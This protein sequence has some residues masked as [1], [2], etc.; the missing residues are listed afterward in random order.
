MIHV[1]L[2]FRMSVR[3]LVCLII[4]AGE[5]MVNKGQLTQIAQGSDFSLNCSSSSG[6]ARWTGPPLSTPMRVNLG[7]TEY[8][9][10]KDFQQQSE[11]Q[12]VCNTE[13]IQ[14]ELKSASTNDETV[15][16]RA[17][18]GDSLFLFCKGLSSSSLMAT[19]SWRPH[20][21]D[22][23]TH[24]GQNSAPFGNRLSL[25]LSNKDNDFS[26]TISP[27]AWSDSGRYECQLSSSYLPKTRTVF[28]LVVVRGTLTGLLLK[29]KFC[30]SEHL[31]LLNFL[32]VSSTVHTD[33]QQLTEGDNVTLQCEVS[34]ELQSVRLYWI[35]TETQQNFPNPL[36]LRNVMMGQRNWACAAFHSSK[37]KALIPLTL[38]ISQTL[39]ATA[40][41]PTP[42]PQYH[43]SDESTIL[44]QTIKNST[45]TR[46]TT[47][48]TT[49]PPK[50]LTR[51]ILT[52]V[53][54]L[55]FIILLMV[56]GA[57]CW[58]TWTRKNSEQCRACVSDSVSYADISLR[59][60]SERRKEEQ[61]EHLTNVR[62]S[63]TYAE[64]IFRKRSDD[65]SP[66]RESNSN[67]AS[68]ET[69]EVLYSC[70]N[71]SKN[72]N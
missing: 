7:Q 44:L 52:S 57:V 38:N 22:H 26:L 23:S 11:G 2:S 54:S 16:F 36:Q 25:S 4:C 12:Y 43:T 33:R 40:R 58:R 5:S 19:W 59:Q 14:L 45:D 1:S 64:V 47:A 41:S 27:T 28:E 66:E 50:N 15:L 30:L 49:Q 53:C 31:N 6:Q 68:D 21:S 72:V 61:T 55:F 8:L 24:L 10:I 13:E 18:Q 35:N 71:V 42:T 29:L 46:W 67:D 65:A 60:R 32:S 37:L 69:E 3:L 70:V 39:S 63:V 51:T 48:G 9:L 20:H 56:L 62:D 17:S 34:H